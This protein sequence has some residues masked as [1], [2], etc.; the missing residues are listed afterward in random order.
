MQKLERKFIYDHPCL[1]K[2]WRKE[3][4]ELAFEMECNFNS[5]MKTLQ[6]LCESNFC[7][8]I[9]KGILGKQGNEV[10]KRISDAG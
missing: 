4:G 9:G 10:M 3:F 2:L 6:E 1:F 7:K 5:S 8:E